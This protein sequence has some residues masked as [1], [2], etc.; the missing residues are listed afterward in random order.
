MWFVGVCPLVVVGAVM[1]V[2]TVQR[3]NSYEPVESDRSQY[4]E[5]DRLKQ[6]LMTGLAVG[7]GFPAA[8]VAMGFF[9]YFLARRRVEKGVFAPVT[10]GQ[11]SANAL[12]GAIAGRGPLYLLG[13]LVPI[14]TCAFTFKDESGGMTLV[15]HLFADEVPYRDRDSQHWALKWSLLGRSVG[16]LVCER[17]RNVEGRAAASDR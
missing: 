7:C 15:A 2:C 9:S 12:A 8:F 13:S 16:L 10:L 5:R 4:S 3:L 1:V 17:G 6:N 14:R 11:A